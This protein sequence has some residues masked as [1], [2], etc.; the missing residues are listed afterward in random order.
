MTSLNTSSTGKSNAA[1]A[2]ITFLKSEAVT[3]VIN[4]MEGISSL[5]KTAIGAG[6]GLTAVVALLLLKKRQRRSLN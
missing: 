4:D 2:T 6:I 3:A 5:A 1:N